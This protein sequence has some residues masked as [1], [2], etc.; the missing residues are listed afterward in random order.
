[1]IDVDQAFPLLTSDGVRRSSSSG[2]G[3][4]TVTPIVEG[5]LRD[6]LGW[7][8]RAQDTSA[9][10]AAL[11][12]S[13][14]LSEVE[15]HVVATYSPRGFAMQADL[16]AVTG[17]QASLYTRAVSARTQMLTLL[18]G[19][20]PLRPDPDTENCEA[21]R[22]LVRNAL[23][24]LVAELGTPGGPRVAVVDSFL[25]QLFGMPY[26]KVPA[27][28]NADEVSGQL[29]Q[30]RV[31][32][33]LQDAFVNNVD[34]EGM[35]TAFWTL[36]D[37]VIDINRAWRT[38]RRQFTG[39]DQHGFLG[40]QLVLIN[41]LLSATAEQVDEVE[42]ALDSVF[43]S[44]AERQT[45]EIADTDGLTVDELLTWTRTFV[46]EEGPRIARD[47]G[48]DGIATSFTPTVLNIV[49]KVGSLM[50]AIGRQ[51][52]IVTP[53]MR[54]IFGIPPNYP[55][56]FPAIVISQRSSLPMPP[57]MRAS[58]IQIGI[59]GLD[60]LLHQLSAIAMRIGR[61]T[62]F[63]LLDAAV[64][65]FEG[66][67]K[68]LLVLRGLNLPQSF[69][70]IFHSLALGKGRSKP[71]KDLPPISGLTTYDDDTISAV[72]D[73]DSL[74]A[75]LQD[76][77]NRGGNPKLRALF[78]GAVSGVTFPAKVLPISLRNTVTGEM[79]DTTTGKVTS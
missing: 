73:S 2:S 45:I 42:A 56:Q 74:T 3:D 20:T 63:A 28:I 44:A 79:T 16:G 37:L 70:P 18:D 24:T 35:R 7:R 38:L 52:A 72:Y 17:G 1:M 8:P 43:V 30:L 58:R 26:D 31:L 13:F 55:L 57:G 78:A 51:K 53:N 50:R 59:S 15:G 49:D 77:E 36:A 48:R 65:N 21:F 64:A 27:G 61:E 67:T 5:A 40:T 22:K 47:S 71:L 34:Q 75:W 6:V 54:D 68:T 11:T 23:T 66:D 33:G 41:R 32:F 4:G 10:T 9:F 29:E 60:S 69:V 39:N 19:L 62:D 46:T 25:R 76:Y 12:A 14:Q